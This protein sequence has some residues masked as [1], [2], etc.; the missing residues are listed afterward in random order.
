MSEAPSTLSVSPNVRGVI[1]SV[2]FHRGARLG[3]QERC[4]NAVGV[5]NNGR[6]LLQHVGVQQHSEAPADAV[7]VADASQGEVGQARSD[8]V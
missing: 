5:G 2:W 3:S 6:A 4:G 8:E 1:P 7:L